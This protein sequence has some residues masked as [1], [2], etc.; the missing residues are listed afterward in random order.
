[1]FRSDAKA[2]AGRA[3]VGGWE[4]RFSKDTKLCKWYYLELT[5]EEAPWVFSKENDP[6]RV[7]AAL[8]LLGTILS[9]ILF[10]IRSD[11]HMRRLF[12]HW[13]NGQPI[14]LFCSY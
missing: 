6:G 13:T 7:I 2:E 11:K 8:D 9:I 1:M 14:E 12:G 4:T 5:A 3:F 10:D